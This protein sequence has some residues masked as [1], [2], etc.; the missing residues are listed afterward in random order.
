[1]KKSMIVFFAFILLTPSAA[2]SGI[3]TFK[4]G[5]FIPGAQ[6]DL[7]QDEFANMNF[8]KSDYYNSNFAFSYEYFMTKQLSFTIGLEGF[9]KNNGGSYNGFIGYE[10]L[11]VLELD[12]FYDFAFPDDY[13]GEDFIP[14]HSF[15]V[16]STPLLFS[17]KLYPLGRRGNFIPYIGGGA[18]LYIWYVRIQ[19]DLIDFADEWFYNEISG[20]I[21][22]GPAVPGED[23]S[24]YPVYYDNWQER[25]RYSIG[26]HAFAGLMFPIA[27]RFSVEAE[28]KYNYTKGKFRE[29]DDAV[30]IGF[31][32]FDLSGYQL[33]LGINYWF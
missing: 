15:T 27:Q 28:F 16:S 11:Y 20:V 22:S 10:S 6:S 30:F 7:W 32:P 9:H 13:T 21:H 24:I 29:G 25:T 17:L 2:L 31:E 19:G 33:S 23:I 14:G 18:G 5:F 4:I 26:Y 3:I 8:G 1:M 12:D